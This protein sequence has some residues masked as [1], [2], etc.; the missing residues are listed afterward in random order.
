MT[1][2]YYLMGKGNL[3]RVARYTVTGQFR[4]LCFVSGKQ[5]QQVSDMVR[6]YGV[7]ETAA[8]CLGMER[9]QHDVTDPQAGGLLSAWRRK[10]LKDGFLDFGSG[11]RR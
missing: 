2:T 9:W 5:P 10:H 1:T 7:I 4:S 11:V 6:L 8:I 3:A